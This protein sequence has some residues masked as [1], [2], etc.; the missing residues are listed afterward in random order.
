MLALVGALHVAG[1]EAIHHQQGFNFA[2]LAFF[3][4]EYLLLHIA[5]QF[6]RLVQRCANGEGHFK[7]EFA[8]MYLGEQ[9]GFNRAPHGVRDPKT[10]RRECDHR[11]RAIQRP[12]DQQAIKSFACAVG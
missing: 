4:I 11:Y 10:D 1:V 6:Y 8:L 5:K 12:A 7:S 3:G 2:V 9:F